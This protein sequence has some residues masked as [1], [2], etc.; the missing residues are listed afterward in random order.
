[1]TMPGA[2]VTVSPGWHVMAHEAQRP[3][4]GTLHEAPIGAFCFASADFFFFSDA[5][6]GFVA[7]NTAT[8]TTSKGFVMCAS[9]NV[10]KM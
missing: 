4:S 7:S 2:Q 5:N 9:L 8:R 1:M 6:A 3:I 10:A